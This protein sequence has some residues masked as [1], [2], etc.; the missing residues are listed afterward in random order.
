VC[1]CVCVCVELT[2]ILK[3]LTCLVNLFERILSNFCLYLR[4]IALNLLKSVKMISRQETFLFLTPNS[5]LPVHNSHFF[6]AVHRLQV[7]PLKPAIHSFFLPSVPHSSPIIPPLFITPVILGVN[8]KAWSSSLGLKRKTIFDAAPQTSPRDF[9]VRDCR[10][11]PR[12]QRDTAHRRRRERDNMHGMQSDHTPSSAARTQA[13]GLLSLL[14]PALRGY[15]S[16][17]ADGTAAG[18]SG[19]GGRSCARAEVMQWPDPAQL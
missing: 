9:R 10:E 13:Q 2:N 19:R 4:H 5:I 18:W 16:R 17:A 14:W 12:G 6:E 8:C 3:S 7:S 1:V 15:N 11:E